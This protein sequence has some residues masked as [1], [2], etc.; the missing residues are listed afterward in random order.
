VPDGRFS[1]ERFGHPRGREPGKSYTWAAGVLDDI[2]GFDPSVFGISPREAEQMDPQQR[3][4]LQL[5]WEALEDA[6]IR[7]SSIAGAD[8]GVFVGASQTD[9]AHA[10]FSDYAIADAQFATGTALAVLA[11]RISYIFDL[12]GPSVTVDTACSSSLVALHQ[13]VEALQSGRID[14]AIVA[15]I[16]IIASPASFI[17]FSQASMLSPTGLCQAFSA[18]AD[19]FVR[20]EG[21]AVLVLRKV[22]SAQAS[23]NPVHG[24]VLATDVNSDGRTNGI[25]LPNMEAQE[26]LLQRIYSRS[27]ID[28]DRLAFVEAHGTGTAAG[29]PIEANAM[30]RGIGRGR[31][32][33]LP[34][35]SIKT[36]IGHLE[37]ASG[38]AGLLKA[39]LALNHGILPP[40]LHFNEPN[41]NID[42][43][44]LN[45]KV[46]DQS[47]LLPN[48]SQSFAGVNSFGFGGTNAHAIVAAGRKSQPMEKAHN[49][50]EAGFFAISAES[51]PALAQLAQDYA[52]RVEHL[53]D[54]DTATLASAIVYRRDHLTHRAV[55]STARSQDVVKALTA[56]I[57]G[58]EDSNLTTG[59]AVGTDNAVA[60]VYSGNGSQWVGMGIAAYNNNAHFRAHFDQVDGYFKQIAGWSL[61]DTLFSNTLTDR[62][63]LTSIGQPLLF[64]IQSAST[65][66]LRARGL[67]PAA[68][69]GHSVGEVAAAEAAGALDLRT[70]IKVIYYR[71]THQELVRGA[72]RMAAVLASAEAVTQLLQ[73]IGE[74]QVEIAAINSPRAVT[75]VGSA[76]ALAAFKAMARS[77]SIVM[78]DLDLDYPFHSVL[79]APV[80]TTLT[81]DLKNIQPRD[82]DVPFVSTV[83]GACVPG[84][85]L[86]GQYWWRNVR[87][88]VHFADA[89]REAAKLG[90]RYF[91]EIGPR[92]TLLKH[93]GDSLT[94]EVGSFGTL[95]VLDRNDENVDP[96]DKAFAKA[97]VGGA[98]IDLGTAFGSDPGPEIKLPFYPW[99]QKQFRYTATPEAIGV[100]LERHPFAGARGS[101]DTLE[102]HSHIDTSL[103]TELADHVVGDQTI[104]PGTAFFEIALAVA[105]Q[106]M[107]TENVIITNFEIFKPLDLTN[108]ETREVMTRVSPGSNTVEIF[109]RPRLSNASWLLHSRGKMHHGTATETTRGPA[110]GAVK[111][112]LDSEAVYRIADGSGLHYGPAFRLVDEAVTH[113]NGLISVQLKRQNASTPF[114]I[115]PM[116]LDACSH[117]LFTVFPEL[118]VEERVVTYIPVRMEETTLY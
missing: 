13:A 101:A 96:F 109:S 89:V 29:D 108:G 90:A 85:R 53:S 48:A 30:G 61:K 80:E 7:P 58:E 66:A 110:P 33:P 103:Y 41:P 60:F 23:K 8:V 78:V 44:H 73:E 94:G 111:D 32:N 45:L 36:N 84:S 95:S 9:Y 75:I 81:G 118:R 100:E 37:P 88:P 77:R 115:D 31:T 55:V 65:A 39:V 102:W 112:R 2:W 68:V 56:Y 25:S 72:G 79:M 12:R 57:A 86:G 83:T 47:L 87:E 16:N 69:I 51:R 97:L 113:E 43:D 11:N 52:G 38:F 1:L 24:L 40:S 98:Q 59:E 62:L 27:A 91:V 106:W 99:Q 5:T 28:V 26:A 82:A 46:C 70:A 107:R 42:F 49:G 74:Q 117:G 116:R 63:P 71:S 20:G 67:H 3:I 93:I 22:A 35:G 105:Q 6:G 76:D 15:G 18:K 34:I 104:F 54:Q 4:L 64:A 17:A 21:G 19:G 10:F 92:P 50:S 114:L 14:T